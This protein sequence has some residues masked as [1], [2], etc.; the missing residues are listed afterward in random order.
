VISGRDHP[1][2]VPL[3]CERSEPS[4]FGYVFGVR[5]QLVQTL[6]LLQLQC[7][8]IADVADGSFATDPFRASAAQCSLC[9][10][11]DRGAAM[12]RTTRSAKSRL[13]HRSKQYL[14]SITS[15]AIESTPDGIARPRAFAVLRLITSSSF[16]GRKT[17]RS[18]GFSPLRIRPV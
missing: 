15:S 12:Q 10:K 6:Q 7:E 2:T 9:P 17:G 16:V 5:S 4:Q 18:A 8:A 3:R 1:I 11:S 14:Y 13:M